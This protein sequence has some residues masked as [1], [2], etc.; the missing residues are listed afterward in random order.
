[1]LDPSPIGP[2]LQRAGTGA[3]PAWRELVERFTPLVRKVCRNH[4]LSATD[5]A[6]VCSSVWLRLLTH[7]SDIRE[8]QAV[9]GWLRT[10]TRNECLTVLRRSSRQVPVAGVALLVTDDPCYAE[11]LIGDERRAAARRALAELPDRDRKLLGLLFSDPPKSYKE[12][13]STLGIPVGAIGPTRARCLT[14]IRRTPA[15]A[16]L[17][18]AC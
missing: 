5:A 17:A 4:G 16:A 7:L 6:D 2:L 18:A 15:I 14:R 8:P 9:P 11:K 3:E 12:I 10:V 13:S 1:M